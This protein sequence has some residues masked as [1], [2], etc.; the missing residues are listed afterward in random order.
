MSSFGQIV[1][2]ETPLTPQM[3]NFTLDKYKYPILAFMQ[4]I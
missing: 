4:N 1:I 2:G 3:A